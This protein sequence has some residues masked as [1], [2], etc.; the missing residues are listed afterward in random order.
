M[1]LKEIKLK[2]FLSHKDTNIM[3][4]PRIT[5][6]IGENGAG[7]SSVLDAVYY[8]LFKEVNR[9]SKIDDLIRKG[10]NVSE[11]SLTFQVENKTYTITRRR[12]RNGSTRS[13]L[14]DVTDEST[15]KTLTVSTKI[16]DKLLI[17]IIGLN[18]ELFK[19]AIYIQQ[20]EIIDLV[21]RPS[22]ERKKIIGKLLGLDKYETAYVEMLKV[23]AHFK[24]IFAGIEG[25]L[26][27]KDKLEAK[28][29]EEIERLSGIEQ[30][31]NVLKEQESNLKEDLEK[32][33]STKTEWDEKKNQHTKN[34]TQLTSKEGELENET[35]LKLNIEEELVT[36]NNSEGRLEE[37]SPLVSLFADIK[38]AK[39][40]KGKYTTE[41][42]L[43][44]TIT[45]KFEQI[46]DWEEIIRQN[47]SSYKTYNDYEE[48]I[49]AIEEQ[50]SILQEAN[51]RYQNLIGKKEGLANI[52]SE[53]KEIINKILTIM[54]KIGL[55]TKD[56][57]AENISLLKNKKSTI[58]LEIKTTQKA[59]DVLNKE[60]G[61]ISGI[62]ND[63]KDLIETL[64]TAKSICPVC[65]SKLTEAHKK[66]ALLDQKLKVE[67][68][69]EIEKDLDTKK[70]EMDDLLKE[71]EKTLNFLSD[72]ADFKVLRKAVN[73]LEKSTDSLK[74]L[75][76][77]LKDLEE[78]VKDFQEIKDQKKDLQ[79]KQKDLQEF[80]NQYCF[81][82]KSLE[83]ADKSIL[84]KEK[85]DKEKLIKQLGEELNIILVKTN[86]AENDIETQYIVCAK[87][88]EERI[89][90]E[91]TINRKEE[92]L[93]NKEENKQRIKAIKDEI[94]TLKK[95][96]IKIDY[97]ESEYKIKKAEFET[98]QNKY[99]KFREELGS[100][101]TLKKE[102]KRSNKILVEDI[103]VLESKAIEIIRLEK[104]I[105]FLAKIRK[106]FHKDGIQE[107]IR[108][109]T[110]PLIKYHTQ[111][112][113]HQFNLPFTGLEITDDYNIQ[114]QRESD[115][116]FI[117]EISG[118]EKTAAA[119]ALRLGIAKALAGKELELVMLDEPTIHLDSQRRSELVNIILQ[120]R[121]I[122]QII[123]VSHDENMKKAADTI[124]EVKIK[125]GVSEVKLLEL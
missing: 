9:G 27:Q 2:N 91:T 113:F 43:L 70:V 67:K 105:Q 44:K 59:I 118:G 32:K 51:D 99:Q 40:L 101:N 37:I 13:K 107:E 112:L 18:K 83:K 84:E 6:L 120:L 38:I 7:K 14:F 106:L 116:F 21:T 65:K 94:T 63:T 47:T 22:S 57:Y 24:Q 72:K 5:A 103:R 93:K 15:P 85:T 75:N 92:V 45:D 30:E 114:L 111:D 61:K 46:L 86:I 52:I 121:N 109:K 36:I 82:E 16:A 19:N 58:S 90:L 54:H 78:N 33:K 87:L 88:D 115:D 23:I 55:E 62:I 80:Y 28:L 25:E 71:K 123:L 1:I 108:K 69:I 97:I 35:K 49:K 20:G 110:K 26:K 66:T 53:N 104:Y 4:G 64:K 125:N 3:I 10:E 81:A 77:E 102:I 34:S 68:N 122:P 31:I 12:N 117:K 60:I 100:K 56:S 89:Q 74:T 41:S 48:K 124:L 96:L 95:V 39:E 76:S 8:T 50:L 42:L 73:A 17:E 29:K 119:L 11:V 79:S 98:S